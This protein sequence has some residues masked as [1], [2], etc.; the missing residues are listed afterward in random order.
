[1]SNSV[2]AD[3]LRSFVERIEY[4]KEQIAE[5]QADLKEV[6]AEAKSEGFSVSTIN[7]IV[8]LRAMGDAERQEREA[9]LDLYKAA[10]GMLDGTPLGKAA[11]DRL[12]KPSEDDADKDKKPGADEGTE[13]GPN[14]SATA[15]PAPKKKSR[16]ASFPDDAPP[17]EAPGAAATITP[18]DIDE[19]RRRGADD[20]RAG[21]N[22][23]S[24]PFVAGDPRRAAW[25]EGWCQA[26]GSDG[27]E[28][29]AALRPTKK[30]KK[31]KPG[32]DHDGGAG[33]DGGDQ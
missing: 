18:E 33:D 31:K 26:M 1:M 11:L 22:I 25:D 32:E 9:L 17:E 2:A 3:R 24:N 29:P 5:L 20:A 27:M 14:D 30:P 28:L 10:L 19:A 4:V 12:N 21:A 15:P 23:L 8:K 6:K 13:N 16:K 7:E